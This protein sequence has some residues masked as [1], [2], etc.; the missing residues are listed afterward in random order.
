[1]S[2]A[3][4]PDLPGISWPVARTVLPPPVDIKTTPSQREFRSRSS[5]VPRY[6]YTLPFEFLRSGQAQ[7]EWQTLLG[8]YNLRGGPFDDW[9]FFDKTDNTAAEQV[10]GLGDGVTTQYQLV[11]AL[12]GFVE[13]VYGITGAQTIKVA[14]VTSGGATV[15]PLG[16]VTLPAPAA[17]G[18][19]VTWSGQFCWRCRF[20]GDSQ[21]FEQF[22]ANFW[23]AKK[24]EFITVKP[25]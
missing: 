17:G 25:L 20:D 24:V 15:S 23:S 8:F 22:M 9:L 2:N 7:L 4:F 10:I 6:R 18:A 19:A 11:R 3:L 14:G 21:A 5:T 12:G 16:L 1:M 13:P